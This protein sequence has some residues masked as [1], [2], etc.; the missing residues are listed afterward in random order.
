MFRYINYLLLL[1]LLTALVPAQAEDDEPV[2]IEAVVFENDRKAILQARE[3]LQGI[4]AYMHTQPDLFLER[5][6]L[7]K[8]DLSRE[9]REQIWLTWQSYLDYVLALDSLG[10][11]YADFNEQEDKA[12]RKT[13]FKLAFT[14]FLANY[15]H[16]LE[17]ID[18]TENDPLMHVVLNEPVPELGLGAETY[19]RM[20]FRF[21]NVAI[22]SE[23][24][25]LAATNLFFGEADS[26]ALEA[27]LAADKQFIWKA[28]AAKG[29][30]HTAENGVQIVKDASVSALFPVQKGVSSWMGDVKVLRKNRS[31]IS[32]GQIADMQ[33]KLEPGDVLLERREWYLSNIG[34]PGYWPHA[35]LYIGT[36]EERAAYFDVPEVRD[37]LGADSSRHADINAL[38]KARYPEAYALSLKP[39]EAGHRPRVL[40]AIS[41]GVSFT[42]LEHSADADSVVVLRPRLSKREKALALTRAF[43]YS[44]RPYDFNFDFLTDATLVCTEL[45]YKSYEPGEGM[46]GLSFPLVSILGRKATPAN[47]IARQFDAHF[48]T[49]A[50]QFDFVL[51]LDGHER[52]ENAVEADVETFRNSWRR[53]KWHIVVQDTPLA[54]Y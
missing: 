9:Q 27:A 21:L 17:L 35:A 33:P 29:P 7:N 15:R 49:D 44:G 52:D 38:L 32:A 50:Q 41:E 34:L 26:E 2:E 51:F 20:K 19:S 16:A 22:G 54:K 31:L 13:A 18:I 3:G 43:H 23:F 1:M 8:R 25:A 24:A 4:I 14:A 37:W 47:E 28:G 30:L 48:G 39:Q 36:A 40:E 42:T 45:V 10:Q 11:K 12:V 53:P 46:T 5:R 6:T